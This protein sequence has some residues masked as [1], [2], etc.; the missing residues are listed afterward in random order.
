M[1]NTRTWPISGWLGDSLPKKSANWGSEERLMP[2]PEMRGQRLT[3]TARRK[4]AFESLIQGEVSAPGVL[5][6]GTTFPSYTW[7]LVA[8]MMMT[9][10]ELS[11]EQTP[12]TAQ[13]AVNE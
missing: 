6:L 7:V 1:R 13:D 12:C 10:A 4:P 11:F 2:S 8:R 5:R 9:M 3:C